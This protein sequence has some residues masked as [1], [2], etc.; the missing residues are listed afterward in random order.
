MDFIYSKL[1]NNL[2]DINRLDTVTLLKCTE[3]DNPIIGL[4]VGDYYLKFTVVNSDKVNYCDLSDLS[5]EDKEL[6]DKLYSLESALQKE[7][8]DRTLADNTLNED[9]TSKLNQEITKRENS[10]VNILSLLDSEK[11]A[12][13]EG[14]D[15]NKEE[16]VA[17]KSD[18]TANKAQIANNTTNIESL[19][20]ITPTGINVDA[21][22]Y[23]VLEHNGE[24]L[25]GQPKNVKFAQIDKSASFSEVTI[26]SASSLKTKDGTGFGLN[27]LILNLNECMS[28]ND[29]NELVQY[30]FGKKIVVAKIYDITLPDLTGVDVV[31]FNIVSAA[32]TFHTTFYRNS[33]NISQFNW[34]CNWANSDNFIQMMAITGGTDNTVNTIKYNAIMQTDA[35]D[36]ATTEQLNAKQDALVSGTNIKTI[37]GENVLGNGNIT[38]NGLNESWTNT[39]DYLGVFKNN[40]GSGFV[41][42][43]NV[44]AFYVKKDSVGTG[45]L[46]PPTSKNDPIITT[47]LTGEENSHYAYMPEYFFSLPESDK[48]IFAGQTDVTTVQTSLDTEIS[49][50]KE[51][52]Q[53]LSSEVQDI[54]NTL[55]AAA[56]ETTIA[57]LVFEEIQ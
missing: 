11:S 56:G 23:A 3:N 17:L 14:D 31:K 27:I 19:S 15:Q 51:K 37:N 33:K 35:S 49:R 28:E 20:A 57:S 1:N 24:E 41:N 34:L 8:S 6:A 7:I 55:N 13:K 39:K 25:S 12:R 10:D 36:L 42:A 47:S 53:T 32:G 2:V 45:M 50:A 18:N 21:D 29:Y 48:F 26:P 44:A 46:I 43:S 30:I 40:I 9:L 38:I 16:I 54:K 5:K 22:G 52:E 4:T